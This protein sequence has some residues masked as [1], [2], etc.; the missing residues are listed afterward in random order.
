MVLSDL[1]PLSAAVDGTAASSSFSEAIEE[2]GNLP[3]PDDGESWTD[4]VH[5]HPV[6]Q[7][8][9]VVLKALVSSD[10]RHKLF[11]AAAE[12][13]GALQQLAVLRER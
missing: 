11:E 1:P 7:G 8:T 13:T 6:V 3:D 12:L 4:R 2:G 9:G 5:P 10:L